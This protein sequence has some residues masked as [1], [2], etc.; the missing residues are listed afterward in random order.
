MQASHISTVCPYASGPRPCGTST[1]PDS[2]HTGT[3][4]IT[5]RMRRTSQNVMKPRIQ[6]VVTP[7][8]RGFIAS[9]SRRGQIQVDVAVFAPDEPGALRRELSLGET[10]RDKGMNPLVTLSGY[11]GP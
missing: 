10:T 7:W 2:G 9:G 11:T 3:I 4:S 6:C 8:I 5:V 1:E